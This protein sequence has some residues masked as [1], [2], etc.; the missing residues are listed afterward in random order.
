VTNR[1]R[2]TERLKEALAANSPEL[3]DYQPVDWAPHAWG[4]QWAMHDLP[5]ADIVAELT[6]VYFTQRTI[7]RRYLYD[8]AQPLDIERLLIGTL[9]WGYGAD[10]KGRSRATKTVTVRTDP[11]RSP[12]EVAT[13]IVET[14][15]T[16]GARAGFS[17]L[18]SGDTGRL[19]MMG[20]AYGTKLL[21]FG[22]YHNAPEPPPLIF[23]A[24]AW[25]AYTKEPGNADRPHPTDC[26]SADYLSY[27]T[28]CA[29]V[30]QS[31]TTSPAT[32]EYCLF[33]LR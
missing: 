12:F 10:R 22:G 32:V 14:T 13:E 18:F 27:C 17:A 23:D 6:D 33:V 21:H 15:Q 16:Q 26:R 29:D 2:I 4:N 25:K 8:L 28:W 9:A 1:P 31:N 30:A 3:V 5:N 7:P 24:N 11:K 20:T 19:K